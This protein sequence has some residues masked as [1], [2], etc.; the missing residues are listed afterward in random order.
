M[1][2]TPARD[3]AALRSA[4]STRFRP[5]LAAYA[6]E[7]QLLP[8]L[9]AALRLFRERAG[10]SQRQLTKKIAEDPTHNLAGILPAAISNWECDRRLPVGAQ[11]LAL[12][13]ALNMT[14]TET[15]WAV[16][17]AAKGPSRQS[18]AN[19]RTLV[20]IIEG[21]LEDAGPKE[22]LLCFQLFAR[23]HW[24]RPPRGRT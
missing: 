21:P 12:T 11:L 4:L 17:L 13:E 23:S 19:Y 22:K 3:T 24:T 15:L 9:G 8:S 5:H 16:E 10:L 1:K 18:A 7:H 14:P 2:R 20:G 6:V